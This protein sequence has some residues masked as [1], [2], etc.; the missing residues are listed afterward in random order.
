MEGHTRANIVTGS[1]QEN[2]GDESLFVFDGVSSESTQ[3]GAE[4]SFVD[5]FECPRKRG[6]SLESEY[7]RTKAIRRKVDGCEL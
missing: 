4:G 1:A 7:D 2:N 6:C 5:A 3:S